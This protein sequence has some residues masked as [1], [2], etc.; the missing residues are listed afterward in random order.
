M[1]PVA[2]IVPMGLKLRH[3]ISVACPRYVW[4]K[5]PLSLFQSLQVLS[6]LKRV[7]RRA[8]PDGSAFVVQRYLV[9]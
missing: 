8:K 1:D 3:T 9:G 7:K 4:Y 6:K 5:S 2:M